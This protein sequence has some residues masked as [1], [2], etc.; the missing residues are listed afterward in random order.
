MAFIEDFD[1][2][3]ST[4]DFGVE[5]IIGGVL[6]IGIFEETFIEVMGVEGLHPVFTCPQVDVSSAVH[7]DE[8]SIGTVPYRVHGIQ[9]DGTGMVLLILE[10][11]G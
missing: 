5:A 2:F 9:K 11:Q 7:G 1:D 4:D 6:V 8:I 10:D 3:F